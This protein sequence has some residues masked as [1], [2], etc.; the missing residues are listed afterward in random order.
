MVGGGRGS[1]PTL[2]SQLQT[3]KPKL[4]FPFL[5]GGGWNAWNLVLT[6]SM[7]LG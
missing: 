7:H 4:K 1:D 6:S 2:K 3:F 5:G